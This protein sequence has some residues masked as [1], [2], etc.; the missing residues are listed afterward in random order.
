MTLAP[1]HAFFRKAATTAGTDDGAKD[2]FNVLHFD[3]TQDYAEMEAG[4][5][6]AGH[7]IGARKFKGTPFSAALADDSAYSLSRSRKMKIELITST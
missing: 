4:D 1:D 2:V 6:T 3:G 7:A 5:M